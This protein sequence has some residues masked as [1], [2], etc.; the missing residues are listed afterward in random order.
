MSLLEVEGVTKR[1]GGVDA[2]AGLSFKVDEGQIKAIIG[3]NGA[4]KTTLFNLLTGLERP[5]SGR[6]RFKG[7]D[8]TGKRPEQVAAGG[9]ARTF[10]TSQLFDSMTVLENVMVGCHRW[11]SAGIVDG[12]L[13]TRRHRR[14]ER[15]ILEWSLHCL[16]LAG[17][18][19][20]GELPAGALAHGR[21][22]LLELARALASKPAL[23]LLDEPAA[24]LSGQ[25]TEELEHTLYRV[26]DTGATTVLV[27]H[28]MALVMG[29]SDEVLVLL[30]GAK[31]AEGPPLLVRQ[32]ASVISAYLGEPDV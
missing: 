21:R 4:G 7:R 31:L 20:L 30:G 8:I 12:L 1:F 28:D 14:Q 17:L 25:E 10:Q 9:I 5:D 13:R 32:D 6:V 16:T 3:P 27:E 26:R 23:L 15:E 22:R 24:G 29:S 18:G 2:V 11:T 19:S